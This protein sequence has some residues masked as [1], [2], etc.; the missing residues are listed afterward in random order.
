MGILQQLDL[1]VTIDI[2]WSET[3]RASDFVLPDVSY[4]EVDRGVGTVVGSNDARVFY[5]NAVLPILHDDTR[6]GREIFAGLAAACGVGEYFD[7][8][9]D[10]LAAAQVA[11]FGIDLTA[12]KERGWA[13]AGVQLPPRTGKPVV[14]L[15]GGK[16]ALANDVWERVGLGRVPGW[17]A[18]W[19]SRAGNVS[20]H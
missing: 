20:P 8:T 6:P 5:R 13:D 4:L 1:L 15:D 2:R 9:P 7:F 18:P 14:P 11:P 3:A 10:D 12:L 17:V 16:I 19:W